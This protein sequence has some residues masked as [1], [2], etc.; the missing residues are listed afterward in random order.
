MHMPWDYKTGYSWMIARAHY[1]VY[2]MVSPNWFFVVSCWNRVQMPHWLANGRSI[3]VCSKRKS[4]AQQKDFKKPPLSH[5]RSLTLSLSFSRCLIING[6]AIACC[7]QITDFSFLSMS[8]D[9]RMW[10]HGNV[11]DSDIG[12]VSVSLLLM[13]LLDRV[14]FTKPWIETTKASSNTEYSQSFLFTSI[15]D[16]DW[17][18]K[19][20]AEVH[21]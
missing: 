1:T 9:K 3:S 7:F 6:S 2:R 15:Q 4:T 21:I 19:R 17:E 10:Y 13:L 18:H 16:L 8:S 12:L 5:S 14:M 20:L 11:F